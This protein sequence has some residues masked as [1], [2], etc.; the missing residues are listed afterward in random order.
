MLNNKDKWNPGKYVLLERTKNLY[1][2]ISAELFLRYLLFT[3]DIPMLKTNKD[4]LDLINEHRR[5]NN[6]QDDDY[7][8]KLFSSVPARFRYIK[9]KSLILACLGSL[10]NISKNNISDKFI[11][12]CGIWLTDK[13][14]Q[15]LTEV[16]SDGKIRNR[17]D[18]IKERLFLKNVHF[19]IDP[20]GLS[21]NELR[22][23]INL[24]N[25]TKISEATTETLE[26]FVNKILLIFINDINYNIEKWLG[27]KEMI[28]KVAAAKHFELS[29]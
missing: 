21:Y 27:I 12:S 4:I 17:F 13:E 11:L 24:K 9:I 16:D 2:K 19:R 5:E 18:V 8:D 29:K 26:L 3:C 23:L 15:D 25:K 14:M 28:Q 10:G 22:S 1:D 20:K 6:L 7:V